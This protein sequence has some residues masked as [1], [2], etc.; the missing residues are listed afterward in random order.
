MNDIVIVLSRFVFIILAAIFTFAAYRTYNIKNNKLN[1]FSV[2]Q[3]V[4][5]LLFLFLGFFIL[6]ADTKS[7]E[8]LGML[9]VLTGVFVCFYAVYYAIYKGKCNF[10]ITNML[11]LISISMI[12]LLRLSQTKAKRQIIFVVGGLAICLMLPWIAGKLL[13]IKNIYIAASVVSIIMLCMVAVLG[14]ESYG[15]LL[16]IDFG[17]F[18]LQPFEIV[19]I[20]YVIYL[21]GALGRE[22]KFKN[23]VAAGIVTLIHVAILAY[24]NDFG[25]VLI[26][27][28]TYILMVFV[29]SRNP[30][31]ILAGAVGAGGFGAVAYKYVSHL[32]VR[33]SAWLDPFANIDD[34]GY[35]MC[36]SLFAIVAGGFLGTGLTK[37]MPGKIPVVEKDFIFSAIA[38]E[39]G[40]IV[41]I[42]LILI[43]VN[44]F[45]MLMNMSKKIKDS[46]RKH[47]VFGYGMIYIFQVFLTIGGATKFI[48]ST[49]ITLPFVSYGG[50]SSAGSII[51]I[52]IVLGISCLENKPALRNDK[53]QNER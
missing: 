31:Y 22:G 20:L 34:T 26:I 46:F 33:V 11:M 30:L 32:R 10:L 53:L 25:A 43:C 1:I 13:N 3:L 52:S 50:S 51:M 48:P 4:C 21:A 14:K 49:G 40:A 9:A 36:Q 28:V 41:A 27:L 47:I 42:C 12:M 23:V 18:S 38:E 24:A 39:F 35:Q 37:G 17:I 44:N 29:A 16:S 2:M 6:Y 8:T 45:L 15:A 19:K 7:D 5:I